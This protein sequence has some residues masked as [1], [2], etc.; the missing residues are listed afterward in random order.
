MLLCCINDS[1]F[2]NASSMFN[3]FRC[4]SKN[5]NRDWL[6]TLAQK[7]SFCMNSTET[8]WSGPAWLR[9]L[10]NFWETIHFYNYFDAK[11]TRKLNIFSMH[12]LHRYRQLCVIARFTYFVHR[13]IFPYKWTKKINSSVCCSLSN[14]TAEK[15]SKIVSAS[16]FSLAISLWRDHL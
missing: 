15:A 2:K 9:N 1:L 12:L 14:I 6:Q 5:E 7:Q 4:V 8:C 13:E 10:S 3:V 11:H 16:F